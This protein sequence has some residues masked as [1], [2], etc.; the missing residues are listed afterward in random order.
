MEKPR[1]LV[2][3]DEPTYL[4]LMANVLSEDYAI[5]LAKSGEQALRRAAG[6]GKPDLILLDVQMPG[7]DGHETCRRLKSNLLTAKIPVIFLTARSNETDELHGFELGAVDYIIKPISTPILKIRVRNQIALA[8]QRIALEQQVEERTLEIERTKDAVVCSMGAL[9]EAKD[10]ETANHIHRTR[11]YVR[12]LAEGLTQHPDYAE[13]L[14]KYSINILYRAAPLHDIGKI[15]VP[16]RVLQ[17][18]GPLDDEER[19]EMDRHVEYG[20]D[21]IARAEQEVGPTPFISVAKEI[22]YGHHEKW[23]G[24]GYPQGLK[25]KEIPLSARLMAVADVYDALTTKRHYKEAFPHEQAET[26]IVEGSGTHFDPDIVN[27]F[28]QLS[29]TFR[30]IAT[31]YADR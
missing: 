21:A 8:R 19:K 5:S 13:V 7:M 4:N 3:D 20:R 9:A 22:A 1:I 15:G 27:A 16:D 25:G 6:E 29:T 30:S 18:G 12:L 2:V 28:R 14:D 31:R 10:E 11:E 17:K 23:D 26:F 24:S